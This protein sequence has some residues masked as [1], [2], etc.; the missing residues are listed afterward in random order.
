MRR[1]ITSGICNF[2]LLSSI[3]VV[4]GDGFA[5]RISNNN[6]KQEQPFMVNR[7]ITVNEAKKLPR[8]SWVVLSGNITN[9]LP[10][11]RHYR[12]RDHT[13]IIA[14]DIGPKVWQGLTIGVNDKVEI[15]GEIKII[16]GQT[17]IKV[18]A[19]RKVEA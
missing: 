18:H 15:S 10:G 7:P 1:Y 8:D 19:I 2:L 11:G 14:V 9:T 6:N 3:A 4:Y 12:F 5:G 17:S 16:R 13:E